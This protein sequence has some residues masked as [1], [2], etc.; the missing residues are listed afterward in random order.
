MQ[1]WILIVIIINIIII[2]IIILIL[3][4]IINHIIINVINIF[5]DVLPSSEA[6]QP[7]LH[8]LAE[9]TQVFFLQHL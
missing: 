8:I 5:S 3:L 7:H 6:P 2:I 4:I 1:G 9:R